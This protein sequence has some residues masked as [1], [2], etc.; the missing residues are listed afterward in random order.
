MVEGR[1]LESALT[2][3]SFSCAGYGPTAGAALTGHNLVD[4][5]SFTGS[6]GMSRL[7]LLAA[8]ARAEPRKLARSV[9]SDFTPVMS[10][11]YLLQDV[12]L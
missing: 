5:I 8:Q 9:R 4:K 3:V 6:T 12:R 1:N 2:K 11:G 7:R 10:N